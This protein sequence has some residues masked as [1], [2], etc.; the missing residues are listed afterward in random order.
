[1]LAQFRSLQL[2]NHLH[3]FSTQSPQRT[4][5]K[6]STMKAL[7]M[8]GDSQA[9]VVSDRPLPQLRPGYIMVKTMAVALNPTDWKHIARLNRPGLLSGCDYA[10]VVEETGTGYTKNWKV[11]DRISGFA[12]GGNSVQP[13]DGAFAEHIVVKADVQWRLPDHMSFEEGS[14]LGVGVVTCGQGL[15]QTLKLDLPVD[16]VREKD[17]YVLIYG[18]STATGALGIQFLK[19]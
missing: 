18:G 1:M 16:G 5:H 19:L 3:L 17:E 9:S 2:A 8:K 11:G 7:V 14:T 15:F 4:Y 10:G 6:M 12:H 13:E